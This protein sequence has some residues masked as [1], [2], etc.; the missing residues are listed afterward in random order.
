MFDNCWFHKWLSPEHGVSCDAWADYD[1]DEHTNVNG[2]AADDYDSG[3]GDGQCDDDH[4]DVFYD[5]DDKN[6]DPTRLGKLLSGLGIW[7]GG[8][9]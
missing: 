3:D 9:T 5:N 7:L 1:D 8:L 6:D 2:A 4:D